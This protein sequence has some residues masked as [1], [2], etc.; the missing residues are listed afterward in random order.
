MNSRTYSYRQYG[1]GKYGYGYASSRSEYV[2]PWYKRLF[3]KVIVNRNDFEYKRTGKNFI[4][5]R[6]FIG[7][8]NHRV[9]RAAISCAR[10]LHCSF[11]AGVMLC[12]ISIQQGIVSH[13]MD[14]ANAAR[15]FTAAPA[16]VKEPK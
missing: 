9:N 1:S 14:S 10:F 4:L 11:I 12:F 8:L 13:F 6:S 16:Q 5:S 7:L 15:C 3:R 2:I